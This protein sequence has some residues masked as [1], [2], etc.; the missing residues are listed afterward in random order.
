M[1]NFWQ[2]LIKG[3]CIYEDRGFGDF[4]RSLRSISKSENTK[5]SQ[6]SRQKE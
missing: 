3:L 6:K 4:K 1:I 2:A 5:D